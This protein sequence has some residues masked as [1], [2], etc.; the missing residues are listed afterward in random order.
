MARRLF[1]EISPLT[2][3]ISVV[4]EQFK[5]YTKWFFT[6]ERYSKHCSE[7]KLPILIYSHKSLIR[8]K[9]GNVDIQ[10]Q[11]NKAKNLSLTAPKINGIIIGPG[12]TFSFWKLVGRCTKSKGYLEGLT[13]NNA[14]ASKGIGGG[15]C[16]FTNLIHWMVLH[17]ELTIVEH[18]HHDQ[19]DLFPDFNRALPFGT[20]TSIVYNY[21]DYQFKN[22]TDNTYQLIT[23][24]TDEHLCGELRSLNEQKL[25]YHIIEKDMN[26]S[27]EK[28][29]YYRNN[30]VFRRIINKIDGNIIDEKLIVQNHSKVMYDSKYID[31]NLIKQ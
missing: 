7:D 5:R 25:S 18:H 29:G 3:K 30:K 12:E 6:K 17:S 2:Y 28:D 22:N 1:C 23:Y 10:L 27:L 15:M 11:E 26:F 14:G 19:F 13:I 16:Q 8:R 9:L 31:R 24:T 20:G 4:K 21:L